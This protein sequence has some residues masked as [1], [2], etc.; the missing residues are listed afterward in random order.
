MAVGVRAGAAVHI[1]FSRNVV[2][3][4]TIESFPL[5]EAEFES[6]SHQTSVTLD[7]KEFYANIRNQYHSQGFPLRP[8]CYKIKLR[9][10]I[11]C[12]S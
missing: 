10:R 6:V 9:I 2:L 7:C 5:F 12:L 4:A 1:S 3:E 8:N 11:E